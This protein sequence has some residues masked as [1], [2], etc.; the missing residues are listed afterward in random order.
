MIL[1]TEYHA[2]SIRLR[3]VILL[4]S[5]I[6]LLPSDI[7]FASFKANRITLWGEAEQYH[8]SKG[9]ITLYEVKNITYKKRKR[10]SFT[11]LYF[12]ITLSSV[13]CRKFH[14]CITNAV[15]L[16]PY[17]YSNSPIRTTPIL[18][19]CFV[20]M[21]HLQGFWTLNVRQSL[22]QSIF[23]YRTLCKR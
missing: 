23:I 22:M 3:R 10:E 11:E 12:R 7:C 21:V 2:S 18:R 14:I 5:D 15:R 19:W 20:F 4:R 8:C 17:P 13:F 1:L 16:C 9:N 6:R